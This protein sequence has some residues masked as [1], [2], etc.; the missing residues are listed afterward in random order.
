[1]FSYS[2]I[3]EWSFI[4]TKKKLFYSMYLRYTGRYSIPYKPQN[5]PTVRCYGKG[6]AVPLQA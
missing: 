1:M 3:H 6:K 4:N 2:F 5:L